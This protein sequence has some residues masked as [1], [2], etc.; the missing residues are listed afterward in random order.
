M[1]SATKRN[2]ARCATNTNNFHPPCSHSLFLRRSPQNHIPLTP[3]ARALWIRTSPFFHN[4][5]LSPVQEAI[6]KS[7]NNGTICAYVR[8]DSCRHS[9][10]IRYYLLLRPFTRV[11]PTIRYPGRCPERRVPL[12]VHAFTQFDMVLF[13]GIF[14]KDV[15]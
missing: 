2:S 15:E 1:V 7:R 5:V 8:F 6:S 12:C 13:P 3:S 11:Q 4:N 14:E 10:T 9:Q